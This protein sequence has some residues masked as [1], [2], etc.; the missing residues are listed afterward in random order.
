MYIF[1]NYLNI[2]QFSRYY[3]EVQYSSRRTFFYFFYFSEATKN[4]TLWGGHF[5][6]RDLNSDSIQK[7]NL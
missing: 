5:S 3:V 2:A 4:T 7:I 1:K 6:E